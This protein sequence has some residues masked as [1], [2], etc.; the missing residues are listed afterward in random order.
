MK[1]RFFLFLLMIALVNLPASALKVVTT[2]PPLYGLAQGVLEGAYQSECLIKGNV[3]PHAFSLSPQQRALL[4]DA[5]VIIWMGA[6]LEPSLVKVM[7]QEGKSKTVITVLDLENLDLLEMRHGH[8]E[9]HHHG[10]HHHGRLDPHVWLSPENAKVIAAYLTEFFVEH[11]P[12]D[13][14]D[15]RNQMQKNG[16]K[17]LRDIEALDEE[18]EKKLAPFKQVPF[19]AFHDSLQYIEKSYG[20][21]YRG[22][23][24]VDPELP[25]GARRLQET[26]ER[27]KTENIKCIF[28]ETQFP[29]DIVQKIASEAGVYI[30]RLDP[31]GG[32]LLESEGNV[33]IN[34]MQRLG[35]DIAKCLRKA[36]ETPKNRRSS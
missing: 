12:R 2:I 3:S 4:E 26:M 27:V 9:H 22:A 14:S 24:Y 17:L 32:D 21:A 6:D 36:D 23:I 8:E 28:A 13:N 15:V 33:Y 5:D 11:L 16:Q 7:A 25:L 34:L 10:H 20:L 29:D 35:D 31:L 1:F 30:G 18:L 19:V